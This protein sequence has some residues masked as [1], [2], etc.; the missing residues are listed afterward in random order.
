MR[1][2]DA[3][4][5]I[6]AVSIAALL[7]G[8]AAGSGPDDTSPL[9]LRDGVTNLRLAGTGDPSLRKTYIVQLESPSAA[10]LHAGLSKTRALPSAKQRLPFDSNSAIVRE[11]TKR[12]AAEQDAI[13]AAV[14]PQA[15]KIYS[16]RYGLNGF[17]ARLTAA[18]ALKLQHTQGVRRVWE[19]EVRP[20]STNFSVEFLDLL[21]RDEGLRSAE[22]L[23]G[24]GVVI[25]VI[26]SGIY[27]EH[28][29]LADSVE[30]DRP[31]ACR[32]SWGRSS[33]LGRWLCGR[34]DDLPDKV[35]FEAPEDWNGTCQ[36]GEDF[37]ADDCNNKLI[38]AR[39]FIAGAESTGPIDE[40]EIRSVRDVDGHG[41]HT[42][43]TAA[44]NRVRAAIYGRTIDTI[45]GIAPKARLAAYK[46]CWLRPGD[47]RA[48][49]NTSDLANA[50]DAAVADGVDV[51]N[52]SV[53]TTFLEVTGPDDIALLAAAK[54]G[55]VAV[56]AAG[57]DGPSLG[58][59]GSPAGGPWVI[60]AA[61]SSRE[62]RSSREALRIE[63][64]A[65]VAGLY[66]V[67]ESSFAPRLLDSGTIEA[68]LVLIDDDDDTLDD[69]SNGTT[70]DGCEAIV[71][72]A[73]LRDNVALIQRG[74]CD[75]D[76]KV[77]NAAEAGA[78]AA[79]VYNIAGDPI[80]MQGRR[81]LSDIPALMIGQADAG[82]LLAEIDDG[83]RVDIVLE[84]GLLLTEPDEGNVM[85][86]FSSRGP[87]P[88]AGVLKPDV[89]APGINILAGFS[90]EVANAAPDETYAYLTGTS[91]A[92]PHIAGVAA[93]L[94]QA[95]PDWSSAAIKSALMTTA[96]QDLVLTGDA[97]PATPFDY[98]AGHIVP[99]A[100]L[101]PGLVYD[102]NDVEYDAFACGV[103]SPGVTSER[104]AELATGGVSFA[105]EDLN[106]PSI[107]V[108]RLANSR[109]VSR[110]VTNPGD[111]TVNYTATVTAPPGMSMS[112]SP[113]SLAVGPG[114]SASFD[115]T[116]GYLDGPLDL[117]RFGALT[118]QGNAAAVRS[119]VAVRPVSL[120]AP[121]QI[122]GSGADGSGNFA[123]EFG[124]NGGYQAG[125]HG[126][127]AAGVFEGFV[128][129]DPTKTFTFRFDNGVTGF[130]IDI[131]PDQLYARF[132]LFDA[133]TDGQGSDD[134]DLYVFYC[135]DGVFCNKI[136]ESGEP[137][138][139]EEFN[140]VQ[141]AAGV[142]AVFVHGFATDP[143]A[144]GP[145][146]AFR[147]LGWSFGNVDDQ[148]NLTA[149]GPALVASG[150]TETVNFAWNGLAED[151]IYLGG[152]SHN[153]P[154]GVAG[155][156]VIRI[157]TAGIVVDP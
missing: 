87:G 79:L 58:S 7:T 43:T 46:A 107:A 133:L 135:P 85:G 131:P 36:P 86:T 33:L 24:E 54:A 47:L 101:R 132:A 119:S 117:W 114:E 30:A 99:N 63:A 139:N 61:A 35:L 84:K 59:I 136:G 111:T 138:S 28:P 67:R 113:T 51:I 96:R 25:A 134:L 153:T 80:V 1:A 118:W 45:E 5:I 137:T 14:S 73:A 6:A 150:A 109:T 49:C 11:H 90:P 16:Y 17:A 34:F 152:I 110:R 37:T 122:D 143:I 52:Y 128:D 31:R 100:A 32:S 126:M 147:L 2:V 20:L 10:E 48:S 69:G 142:Y 71:N 146:A 66:A 81:G 76:V 70:T 102:V 12:I 88:I 65:S 22:G 93:L 108:A 89:S 94:R 154:Q 77:R 106:Q 23:D 103:E 121:A 149:S 26:D 74:G 130:L 8:T 148:G 97:A 120:T 83:N 39:W 144:G 57:N 125:V 19:D 116:L 104:C 98:G 27:P 112:V 140:I 13:L 156:T 78:A 115:V 53:G 21:D 50:I 29:A 60:T 82:L 92:T 68:E 38:G 145:G 41:T 9:T 123:I 18:E 4:A 155:L 95:Q 62:G 64:P 40:D 141:P 56:V 157:D 91:M 129:N 15:V 105:A 127:R 55:I 44:G 72:T 3:K 75:F 42:A 151:T 124:Y